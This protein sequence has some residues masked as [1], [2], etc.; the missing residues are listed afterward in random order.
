MYSPRD[1]LVQ[2]RVVPAI[3]IRSLKWGQIKAIMK[4]VPTIESQNYNHKPASVKG[5]K[6]SI[7]CSV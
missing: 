7:G 6:R 2:F 3:N 5:K 4:M 1:L